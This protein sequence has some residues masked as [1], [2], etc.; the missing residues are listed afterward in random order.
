MLEV[1]ACEFI[2]I[3]ILRLKIF[4]AIQACTASWHM[5]GNSHYRWNC[6]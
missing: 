6:I 2:P 1:I 4:F 5:C 3:V